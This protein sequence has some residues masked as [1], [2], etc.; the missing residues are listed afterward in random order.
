MQEEG[1]DSEKARM[2]WILHGIRPET[3]ITRSFTELQN[4]D[5]D[6][7]YDLTRGNLSSIDQT[8]VAL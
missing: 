1:S 3:G 7:P 2:R 8:L 4:E 6:F 5:G